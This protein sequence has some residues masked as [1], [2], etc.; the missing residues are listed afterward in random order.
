[1]DHEMMDLEQLAV[2]LQRDVRELHKLASRG[3]LPGRKVGGQWRFALAEINHWLETQLHG[4][5]AKEL[6]AL[7]ENHSRSPQQPLLASIL[8]ENTMAVPLPATTRS[9][10]LRELVTLAERSWQVYHGETILQAVRQREEIGSTALPSGV[11]FPHPRRPLPTALGDSV[12]AYGRTGTGIPFGAPDG[13]LTDIFFLVLCRDYGT[14][15]RVLARLALMLLQHPGLV[16]DLRHADSL[17][18]TFA[19]LDAAERELLANEQ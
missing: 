6:T 11:A 12:L 7:E 18:E 13:S 9:S 14:H 8:S 16:E 19:L 4:F 3:Q 17:S 15:L 10:V 1:M 2:Y 5:N